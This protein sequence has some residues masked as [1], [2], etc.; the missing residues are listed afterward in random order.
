[1]LLFKPVPSVSEPC[2]PTHCAMVPN[3]IAG[4]CQ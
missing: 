1:M 3:T 4:K 2:C